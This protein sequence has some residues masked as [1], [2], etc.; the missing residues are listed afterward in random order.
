MGTY[1]LNPDY[2]EVGVYLDVED[3]SDSLAL[4]INA[5]IDLY[6]LCELYVEGLGRTKWGIGVFEYYMEGGLMGYVKSEDTVGIIYDDNQ[7]VSIEDL[8]SS[9]KPKKIVRIVDV[10]GRESKPKPNVPLFYIYNDGTVEKR[11][12]VE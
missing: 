4:M 11:F 2:D 12:V 10:L 6:S 3:G 9:I 5:Q 7:F 1:E 8:E